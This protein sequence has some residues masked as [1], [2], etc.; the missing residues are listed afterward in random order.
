MALR[1]AIRA[2]LQPWTEYF[3]GSFSIKY[4]LEPLVP[5][6]SYND[7]VIV[8]GLVATRPVDHGG[9]QPARIDGT[10]DLLLMLHEVFGSTGARPP[11]YTRPIRLL[12]IKRELESRR[13]EAARL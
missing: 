3:E 12:L 2:E 9:E 5:E 4:A 7:L 10:G 1:L 6:L 8:D 13:G 11:V